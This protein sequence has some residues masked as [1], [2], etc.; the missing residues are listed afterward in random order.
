MDN[1]TVLTWEEILMEIK[2][3]NGVPAK[4]IFL[5]KHFI[6]ISLIKQV[7]LKIANA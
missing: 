6:E 3:I 5:S 7:V 4:V 1:K 2:L